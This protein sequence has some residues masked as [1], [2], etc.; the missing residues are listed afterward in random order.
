MD[1][2]RYSL[3]RLFEVL[4]GLTANQV[5]G[6]LGL[7]PKWVYNRRVRGLTWIEADEVAVHFGF[8]PWQIWPEWGVSSGL[9]AF[10]D[11]NEGIAA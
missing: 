10:D 11:S 5:A 1:N 7:P 4:G 3:D 9:T 8:L 2:N 6:S